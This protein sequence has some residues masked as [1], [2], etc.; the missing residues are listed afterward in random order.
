MEKEV[1]KA[2]IAG[3]LITQDAPVTHQSKQEEMK[4]LH[5]RSPVN[6]FNPRKLERQRMF[7]GE[8]PQNPDLT[9]YKAFTFPTPSLLYY[10]SP[11]N[12]HKTFKTVRKKEVKLYEESTLLEASNSLHFLT[13]YIILQLSSLNLY[14]FYCADHNL[15][16]NSLHFKSLTLYFLPFLILHFIYYFNFSSKVNYLLSLLSVFLQI[17]HFM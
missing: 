3:K 9:L 16:W 11:M 15:Q 7:Y 12:L 10:C 8:F 1:I 4:A 2:L 13:L 5:T 17:K 14:P 6:V